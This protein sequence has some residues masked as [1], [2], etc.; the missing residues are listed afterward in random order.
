M[1]LNEI[2]E[3][4]YA[5]QV[6]NSYSIFTGAVIAANGDLAALK[7]AADHFRAALTMEKSV[8][9]KA[10]EIAAESSKADNAQ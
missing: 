6:T 3:R 5:T 1:N 7:I 10:K 2:F 8:L 4:A 9:E